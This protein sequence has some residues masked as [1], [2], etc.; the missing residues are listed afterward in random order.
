MMK[1]DMSRNNFKGAAA[2]KSIGD[3][4][5]GN[6]TLKDLNLSKCNI[7]SDAAQGISTG[8]AGNRVLTSLNLSSNSLKVEGTKIIAEAVKVTKCAIAVVLVLFSCPS[9]HWL[10]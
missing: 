9:D 10:N 5:T 3:M 7:D 1:L 2:G 6:S 4:L 8:L